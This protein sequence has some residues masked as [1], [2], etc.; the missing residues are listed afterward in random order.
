LG[1]ALSAAQED[2][3][4][5]DGREKL[6]RLRALAPMHE[7]ATEEALATG[8]LPIHGEFY[9]SNVLSEES[10]PTYA[11]HPVDWEMAALGPPLIDLAALTSGRWGPD[12]R[13]AM[14]RAYREGVRSAG[15]RCSVLDE[16]VRKA[17]ACRLLLAVQW[18]GWA[19]GWPAPADHRNDWLEEAERSAEELRR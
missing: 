10:G 15:A 16:I 12:D 7:R 19:A 14:M 11:I 1:R 4:R 13:I 18:L 6:A 9:P 17:A 2:A 8:T 5:Q 3:D